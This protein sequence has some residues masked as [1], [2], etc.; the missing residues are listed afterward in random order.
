MKNNRAGSPWGTGPLLSENPVYQALA[1][2]DLG[3]M[4]AIDTGIALG[5]QIGL[6]RNQRHILIFTDR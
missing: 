2:S 1:F 5:I 3:A 4:P 6:P